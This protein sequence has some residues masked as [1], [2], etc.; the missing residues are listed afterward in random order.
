[1]ITAG[2]STNLKVHFGFIFKMYTYFY[3]LLDGEPTLTKEP[4]LGT[5][6]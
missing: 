6:D 2:F 1:M 5:I 3:L 4:V